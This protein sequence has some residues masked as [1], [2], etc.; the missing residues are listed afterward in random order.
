M[1][2]VKKGGLW[3]P[4]VSSTRGVVGGQRDEQGSWAHI[5]RTS[6]GTAGDET[7]RDR[8]AERVRC[9]VR[10]CQGMPL[11]HCREIVL[12]VAPRARLCRILGARVPAAVVADDAK[13]LREIVLDEDPCVAVDPTAVYE[14]ERLAVTGLLDQEP[15]TVDLLQRPGLKPIA[16][17]G[18]AVQ[19][20]G[21][22]R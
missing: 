12:V 3:S 7:E 14:D 21:Q 1:I 4:C 10:R 15:D 22:I 9:E 5:E 19:H 20:H 8:S 18:R 2:A 16:W 11:D 17:I 13:R 6:S